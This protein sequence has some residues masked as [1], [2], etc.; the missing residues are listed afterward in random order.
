MTVFHAG[1]MM[2]LLCVN[3]GSGCRAGLHNG[4]DDVVTDGDDS[5]KQIDDS[6][7]NTRFGA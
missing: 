5:C 7:G 3:D 6:F 2:L 4:Y 1:L